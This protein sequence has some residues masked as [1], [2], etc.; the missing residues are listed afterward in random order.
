MII[1]FKGKTPQIAGDV[2]IAPNAFIIGDVIIGSGSSVWF[3]AV[4]RGDTGRIRIGSGVSVQDNAV[5]HV[6]GRNDTL[7]DNEITIGHAAVLEGCH[8]ED[9]ALIGM[10]ATILDGSTV[11]ARGVVAAGSVVREGFVVPA[12]TLAAGVPASLKGE[13]SAEVL[14][15][16]ASAP[17]EYRG[18]A[19]L[20]RQAGIGLNRRP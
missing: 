4:I 14:A 7:I 10:N 5:I 2:F 8:I 3:G 19:A 16:L 17:D 20:Y 1:P 6:N 18:Y 9:G 13:I 15:R 11:K 12:G